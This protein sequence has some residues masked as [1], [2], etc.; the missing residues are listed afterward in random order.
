MIGNAVWAENRGVS[1][2]FNSILWSHRVLFYTFNLT[3]WVHRVVFNTLET[4]SGSHFVIKT[5]FFSIQF[6]TLMGQN[7]FFVSLL[8]I[9]SASNTFNRGLW[10]HNVAFNTFNGTLWTH[11][12]GLNVFIFISA[13]ILLT[14]SL[15]SRKICKYFVPTNVFNFALKIIYISFLT[16]YCTQTT[17]KVVSNTFESTLWIHIVGLNI[18]ETGSF[19]NLFV[20]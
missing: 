14:I 4:A 2:V 1:N 3:L 20:F 7:V 5:L 15:F 8:L 13:I 19:G 6:L 18:L 10:A 16:F 12:M 11:R 17:Q 9:L